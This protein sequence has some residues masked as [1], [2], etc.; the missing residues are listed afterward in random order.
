MTSLV[1]YEELSPVLKS[2]A[3]HLQEEVVAKRVRTRLRVANVQEI[4]AR[5]ISKQAKLVDE[6]KQVKLRI[7]N[8]QRG[9]ALTEALD[10]DD[11]LL[12]NNLTDADRFLL[13][14]AYRK[15]ATLAHPDKGGDASSFAAVNEAYKAGD[16]NSLQEYFIFREAPNRSTIEYWLAEDKRVAIQWQKFCN[17]NEFAIV[18]LHQQGHQR[19]A[20]QTVYLLL[21]EQLRFH[22]EQEREM[23]SLTQKEH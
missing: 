11:E 2:Y 20:E 21:V 3:K 5:L 1:V 15:A 13:K 7:R 10:A 22:I 16:L 8:L 23:L 4:S 19:R 6:L 14:K 18:Q 17:T 12:D 9:A